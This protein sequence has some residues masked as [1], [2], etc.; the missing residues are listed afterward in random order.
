[1]SSSVGANL[2]FW[3]RYW[4][5]DTVSQSILSAFNGTTNTTVVLPYTLVPSLSN[6]TLTIYAVSNRESYGFAYATSV[7]VLI[8]RMSNVPY[9]KMDCS[10]SKVRKSL[11]IRAFLSYFYSD[12]V[13]LS[14]DA[15]TP[16][17]SWSCNA[18]GNN[19][20]MNLNEIST[21]SNDKNLRID[22][23]KFSPG[24]YNLS[25][26]FTIGDK[27]IVSSKTFEV[28]SGDLNVKI[29]GGSSFSISNSLDFTFSA[30]VNDED[31]NSNSQYTYAWQQC[32]ASGN[33]CTTLSGTSATNVLPANS[34]TVAQAI[35]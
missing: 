29:K 20:L 6:T 33:S 13:N 19:T 24:F 10:A 22:T 27:V 25:A 8:K 4:G 12:C 16:G 17:Y 21:G 2:T 11:G 32:D 7:K 31:A 14:S 35:Q 3:F 26:M 5:N 23:S 30:L 18:V 9:L 28:A 34:L 1:M 15:P